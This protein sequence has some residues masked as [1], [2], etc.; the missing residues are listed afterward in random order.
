MSSSF[1][2]SAESNIAHQTADIEVN[3]VHTSVDLPKALYSFVWHGVSQVVKVR[4]LSQT[5]ELS[6]C[7]V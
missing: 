6:V 2:K 1:Y 4:G 7:G 3:I 5:A